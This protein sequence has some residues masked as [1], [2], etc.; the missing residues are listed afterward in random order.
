MTANDFTAC[1]RIGAHAAFLEYDALI[2]PSARA[3][4]T[5]VVIF[6]NEL[7]AEAV[8][9]RITSEEIT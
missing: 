3:D 8:F 6:L 9:E 5:N 7:P 1:K 2:V 4:G